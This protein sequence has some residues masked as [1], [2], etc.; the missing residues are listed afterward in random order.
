VRSKKG[1]TRSRRIE[2]RG[3]GSEQSDGGTLKK[4][5]SREI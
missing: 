2:K 4:D 5:Q 1:K 3:V